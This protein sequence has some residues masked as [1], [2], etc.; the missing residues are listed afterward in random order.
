MAKKKK[1]TPEKLEDRQKVLGQFLKD[2]RQRAGLSQGQVARIFGFT[3]P[4]FISNWENGRSSPPMKHIAKLCRL[5]PIDAGQ[6][7]DLLVDYS[8]CQA[9]I[10]TRQELKKISLK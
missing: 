4:Q 9:E 2:A 7:F 3:T 8:A 1:R 10:R 5:Y 6:F